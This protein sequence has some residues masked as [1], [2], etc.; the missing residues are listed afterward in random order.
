MLA[1][2]SPAK[3]MDT[4]LVNPNLVYTQPIFKSEMKTILSSIKK[5]KPD[6][7]M[8]LM[9]ISE[10]LAT[11]NTDRFKAFNLDLTLE[12]GAAPAITSFTGEVY[13]GLDA[14]AFTDKELVLANSKISILSGFYGLLNPLD[15]ILPYRLEMGTTLPIG[16][17]KNL[18]EF[19]GKKVAI[20]LDSKMEKTNSEY[21]INLASEEYFKVVKP[22][23]QSDKLIHI[24]FKEEKAGKW[25][26]IS[27]NAKKARGLVCKYIVKNKISRPEQLKKFD[28]ENYIFNE[29]L[30]TSNEWIFTRKFVSV[31]DLPR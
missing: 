1:I 29:S 5:Y 22:H 31:K 25:T 14:R 19:W 9:S 11:L 2:I 21:L 28:Y 15:L 20:A 23:I 6:D 26:F 30:S 13:L 27:F 4:P 17:N 7:L 10:K 24:N 12:N 3:S 18:Y 16:K 8:Q